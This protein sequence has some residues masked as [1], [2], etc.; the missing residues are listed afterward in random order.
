MGLPP[1]T[2]T[3]TIGG[4]PAYELVEGFGEGYDLLSGPTARKAYLVNW[5]QRH[6]FAVGLLGLSNTQSV[7]GSIQLQTPLPY[8]ELNTIYAKSIEVIPVGN[9][10]Q[11]P[12]QIA[13]PAA[14]VI[15]NFSAL[16]WSFSGL[17]SPSAPYQNIDPATPLVWCQQ[18]ITTSTEYQSVN[19][20]GLV[21]A[22]G[23]LLK[24]LHW[25]MPIFRADISLTFLKMPYYPAQQIFTVGKSQ[26]NS[27]KF[28]GL[29]P[30]YVMFMGS[31][32]KESRDTA[33]NFTRDVTFNFTYRNLQWDYTW[34]GV[35]N[36]MA[37][38]PPG[39]YQVKTTGGA[40]MIQSSDLNQ[41]I[42]S[43]YLL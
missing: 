3:V 16:P 37:G 2:P 35:G 6:A 34:D 22:A 25:E 13:W 33:G 42:P 7:G 41:L 19:T 12:N 40:P 20:V 11:G 28:L 10:I 8:P 38:F 23:N 1:G 9:P 36:P 31:S 30:G 15:A 24:D 39:F 27:A 32:Q 5:T 21:T 17:E 14:K 4:V 29:A 26:M 43:A 18:D